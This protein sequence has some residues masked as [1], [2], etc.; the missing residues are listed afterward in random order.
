MGS[1]A[2][3]TTMKW[4]VLGPGAEARFIRVVFFRCRLANELTWNMF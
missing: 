1:R 2:V 3:N 4:I